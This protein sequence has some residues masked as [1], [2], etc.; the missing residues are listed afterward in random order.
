MTNM[1]SHRGIEWTCKDKE[2]CYAPQGYLRRTVKSLTVIVFNP[3]K[4]RQRKG[5]D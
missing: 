4:T 2:T 1:T 3:I 5:L